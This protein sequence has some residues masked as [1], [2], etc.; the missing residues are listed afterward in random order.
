MKETTQL[1][2]LELQNMPTKQETMM[3]SIHELQKQNTKRPA[4]KGLPTDNLGGRLTTT[5]LLL[6]RMKVVPW[7]A[8]VHS[9][10]TNLDDKHHHLVTHIIEVVDLRCKFPLAEPTMNF[11]VAATTTTPMD[12]QDLLVV[13]PL[14]EWRQDIHNMGLH[15]RRM[16]T[17]VILINVL[18][19]GNMQDIHQR[20]TKALH[21]T[22]LLVTV[23]NILLRLLIHLSH[24]VAIHLVTAEQIHPD[25]AL[26][27]HHTTQDSIP[28]T[29]QD[30][31]LEGHRMDTSDLRLRMPKTPDILQSPRLELIP[32]VA[33]CRLPSIE[34]S[35]VGRRKRSCL[36]LT[37]LEIENQRLHQVHML[38]MF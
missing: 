6:D 26:I 5:S 30:N 20:V 4:N 31:I 34:V 2:K 32:S 14:L 1:N 38:K 19:M 3:A 8:V 23:G 21:P 17:L 13:A 18:A 33:Q 11:T 29:P 24:T 35:R 25:G 7:E 15:L 9:S 12:L 22:H 10:R 16:I 36:A 37:S 28:S 27:L